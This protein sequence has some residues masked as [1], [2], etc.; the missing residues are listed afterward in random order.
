[1]RYMV[2][3]CLLAD[4]LHAL[5][6]KPVELSRKTGIPLSTISGYIN[7]KYI[8]KI[9]NARTI[10]KALNCEPNDLYE[11]HWESVE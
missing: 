2:G 1:M 5:D 6:I 11:W 3:K 10:A 4:R 8:M 7:G 9:H